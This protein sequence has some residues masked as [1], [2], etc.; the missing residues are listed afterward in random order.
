MDGRLWSV[1]TRQYGQRVNLRRGEDRREVN[2]F[3][4]PVR[5][6]KEGETPTPLGVSPRGLYLYLGPA[7]EALDGVTAL[8]WAGRSFWVLRHRAVMIGEECLY[9]WAVAQEADEVREY[10]AE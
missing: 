8:E 4:Q 6:K 5:E 10:G 3:F 9:Q 2:A 7:E 1:M